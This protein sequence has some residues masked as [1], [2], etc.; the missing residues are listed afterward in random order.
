MNKDYFSL[1]GDFL[2]LPVSF[3]QKDLPSGCV[4]F[5]AA[6]RHVKGLHSVF[7]PDPIRSGVFFNRSRSHAQTGNRSKI[8]RTGNAVDRHRRYTGRDGEGLD[9]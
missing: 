8:R 3:V 1:F 4:G 7:R 9:D 6:L 2:Y 5:Y